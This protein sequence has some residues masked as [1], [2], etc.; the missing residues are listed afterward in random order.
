MAYQ[1]FPNE[2]E[3]LVE[4]GGLDSNQPF[5]FSEKSVRL[6]FIRKVYGILLCQLS[7]TMVF[8]VLFLYEEGISKY[9]HDNPWLWGI[10]FA[11]TFVCIIA[12]A[13]CPDVRR[14]FPIN[15][16]F[17]AIFTLCESFLL[18]AVASCYKSEEVL[19][20]VGITAVVALGLTI[21]AFQTKWDFTMCNAG[22]LVLLIILIFFGLLCAIIRS[23]ILQIF[24]ASLGALVFSMYLVFDTQ[25][26][27][28]GK[29]QYALSPEEYIFAALNLYL[30]IVN[31]FLFIL[32]IIGRAR[33]D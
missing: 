24:Y 21:F 9:S 15:M 27:L 28:G 30:D 7:V 6:G 33:G 2:G 13:C 26:M 32:S 29:H 31:L 3:V 23:K 12:L 4:D 17:L 1:P 22:L 5:V 8:I 11:L 18:G 19:I 10:A 25:L 14:K 16:I 20:A